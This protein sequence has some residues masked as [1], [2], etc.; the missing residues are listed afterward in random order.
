MVLGWDKDGIMMEY[1]G[2]LMIYIIEY[3]FVYYDFMSMK[4]KVGYD[5]YGRW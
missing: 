4:I 1:D 2:M 5:W 3:F